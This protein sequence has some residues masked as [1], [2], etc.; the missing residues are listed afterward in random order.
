MSNGKIPRAR[1][2]Q[3][4][5]AK[6]KPKI[7]L[8]QAK[9]ARTRFYVSPKWRRLRALKLQI[10]PLCEICQKAGKLV[11]ATTVHHDIERLARP[12]L[13]YDLDNLV[14]CCSP[15]HSIEHNK[16]RGGQP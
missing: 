3:F 11:A 5:Q 14:S 6:P 13:A 2:H 7:D 10:N 1:L 4:P 12:D 15:C 16:R 8:Y 9:L